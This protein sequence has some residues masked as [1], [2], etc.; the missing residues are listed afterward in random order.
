MNKWII[1]VFTTL[2]LIGCSDAQGDGTEPQVESKEEIK[3]ATVGFSMTGGTIEEASGV[4]EDEKEKIVALF[5]EYIQ[6]S[7][8][9][10]IERYMATI[11][12]NP[13]GF[14]YEEDRQN[15]LAIFETYDVTRAADN[16]TIVKYSEDE[17]QVYADVTVTTKEFATN[18]EFVSEGKQ[19]TVLIKE[20]DQWGISS[21]HGMVENN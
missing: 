3:G 2:L 18:N 21:I 8:D 11:T 17:A 4:P 6:A 5:N 9:E 1:M 20:D 16:I 7:N 10:D 14:D 15:T 12:E 19:V 13:K